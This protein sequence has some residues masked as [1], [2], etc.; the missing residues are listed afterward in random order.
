M[1]TCEAYKAMQPKADAQTYL[2][3]GDGRRHQNVV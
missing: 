1:L 3:N 2:I